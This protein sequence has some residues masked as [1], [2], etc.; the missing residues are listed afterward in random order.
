VR[1]SL[2]AAHG[3]D[4]FADGYPRSEEVT[5]DCGESAGD[6]EEMPAARTRGHLF[7]PRRGRYVYLWRTRKSWAGTCRQLV[8]RFDD[9]TTDRAT[10]RF[11]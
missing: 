11:R 4:G 3:P 10:F 6:S 1:F 7:Q 9:G 8:V 2:G 5:C